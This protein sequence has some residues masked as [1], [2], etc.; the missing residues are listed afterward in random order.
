MRFI[1]GVDVGGTTTTVA[2]GNEREVLHVSGQFP[3]RSE[4]GPRES[5]RAIVEH[6]LA[7]L[8]E[9][10]GSIADVSAVGLA[11]PG[12]ATL[13]GV[14]LKTPN[15]TAAEWDRFPIRGELEQGF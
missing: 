8:A 2:I 5:V 6:A 4:E 3:T 15:L 1:I 9:V 12:P 11:T 14:L 7:A 13:D 10:G